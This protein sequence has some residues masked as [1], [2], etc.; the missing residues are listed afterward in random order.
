MILL[1]WWGLAAGAFVGALTP[2]SPR[3]TT[4]QR[5]RCA[6]GRLSDEVIA[7]R[8]ARRS[9][10]RRERDYKGADA[11]LLGLQDAGIKV[12]DF[13]NGTTWS[14]EPVALPDVLALAKE[15]R[16][17]AVDDLPTTVHYLSAAARKA[18]ESEDFVPETHLPGRRAADAA[19]HFAMAGSLDD[20]LFQLLADVALSEARRVQRNVTTCI[21]SRQALEKLAAAFVDPKHPIFHDVDLDVFG[22]RSKLWRWRYSASP[23]SRSSSS[24][25]FSSSSPQ[26][27][28][29]L[30]EAT[31]EPLIIDVGAGLGDSAL[32]LAKLF[33]RYRILGVDNS[34]ACIH[35]ANAAAKRLEI[36]NCDFVLASATEVLEFIQDHDRSCA[37]ILF[38]FPTP[39]SF[40]NQRKLVRGDDAFLF[41]AETL[42]LAAACLDTPFPLL[43]SPQTTTGC[44]YFASN[45]ED[46][47]V[48]A[49]DLAF[50]SSSVDVVSWTPDLAVPSEDPLLLD[51][52]V[53]LREQRWADQV[54]PSR[55]AR[56][57]RWL[58]RSPF[59][60][61][62][63]SE[64]EAMLKHEG[65][66]V[67]R[68]VFT[69][70]S[71]S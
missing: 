23:E 39:F 59:P 6:R 31:T 17:S 71:S 14:R 58:N 15:A 32:G 46:V 64:T 34:P 70:S 37:M 30:L 69:P 61:I 54:P 63:A 57:S 25:K 10:L 55:R 9:E 48:S 7:D 42:D 68:L 40:E 33:P 51:R 49:L 43:D 35:P 1:L 67:H 12:M 65:Q 45:V 22:L 5:R 11:I 21:N 18:L 27:Y 60:F 41:N 28:R 3:A 2:T 19:F 50:A 36:S 4:S 62:A 53:P 38:Q 56:G 20:G 13:G 47:A 24:K 52:R 8:V 44:I 16:A 29:R 66:P 26:N